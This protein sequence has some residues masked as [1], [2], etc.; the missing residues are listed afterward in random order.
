[1]EGRQWL[2]ENERALSEKRHTV[3]I[4]KWGSERKLLHTY[5]VMEITL[6]QYIFIVQVAFHAPNS[7]DQILWWYDVIKRS[8]GFLFVLQALAGGSHNPD[9]VCAWSACHNQLQH[10]LER[11]ASWDDS[12]NILSN[13][14]WPLL[15]LTF[16]SAALLHVSTTTRCNIYIS[17]YTSNTETILASK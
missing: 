17:I 5:M 13:R 9:Y 11:I 14:W 15:F 6:W 4:T 10:S 1:M 7:N 8:G 16:C 2:N 3:G 12:L